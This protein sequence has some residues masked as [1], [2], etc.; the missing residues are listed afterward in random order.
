MTS[1]T[2]AC[3]T[4]GQVSVNLQLTSHHAGRNHQ[5][6]LT[7]HRF[8]PLRF[9]D[10]SMDDAEADSTPHTWTWRNRPQSIHSRIG[11]TDVYESPRE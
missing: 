6:D 11:V 7:G 9:R 1:I 4:A 5:Y 2:R 10:A 3:Y 8:Q